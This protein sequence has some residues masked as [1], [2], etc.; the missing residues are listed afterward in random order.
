RHAPLPAALLHGAGEDLAERPARLG[1]IVVSER[2]RLVR[3][4]EQ[5]ELP[6]VRGRDLH[7]VERDLGADLTAA[8]RVALDLLAKNDGDPANLV[9]ADERGLIENGDANGQ[10]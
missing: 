9:R 7:G 8:G 5:H 3:I 6:G 4:D 10:A 1:E 2:V